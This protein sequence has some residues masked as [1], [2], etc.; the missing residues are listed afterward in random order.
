MPESTA[1]FVRSASA[2]Y[3]QL[4]G[5]TAVEEVRA[6]PIAVTAAVRVRKPDLCTVDFRSIANPIAE[7]EERLVNGAEFTAEELIGL[8]LAYDGKGTSI[9][10]PKNSVALRKTSRALFEPLPGF[11]ALGELGFLETLTRDFL[12][13]DAGDEAIDGQPMRHIGLKPR[14]TYRS[15]LLR[16]ITVPIRRAVVAF[17]VETLFPRRIRFFPSRGT[18]LQAMLGDREHVTIE[19]T[20]VRLE[21]PDEGVF[22]PIAPEGWRLFQETQT[23]SDGW[24]EGLPFPFP[25]EP[26][27]KRGFSPDPSSATVTVDAG[28]ERGYVSLLFHADSEGETE[29]LVTLRAGNYLSKNLG[30]RRATIASEGRATSVGPFEGHV[31]DRGASWGDEVS[32]SEDRTL[33]EIMWTADEVFWFLAGD[34][35]GEAELLDLVEGLAAALAS[36]T[37]ADVSSEMSSEESPDA[38]SETPAEQTPEEPS[39]MP[40]P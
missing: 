33:I 27:L 36:S 14:E 21:T 25:M 3:A 7:L 6:G 26:L 39:E 37:D 24:A 38:P 8:P 30:R 9:H 4:Q 23:P 35:I 22:T 12:V 2:A 17:D 32:G 16:A 19:Y 15:Q 34:A 18:I 40:E 13:R 11:R 10:D 20:D 1:E 28:N 29:R 31:L 5:F